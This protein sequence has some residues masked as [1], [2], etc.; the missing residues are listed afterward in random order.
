MLIK[1]TVVLTPAGANKATL[2]FLRDNVQD[3]RNLHEV[4]EQ[5]RGQRRSNAENALAEPDPE[6]TNTV[7]NAY[8]DI[9]WMPTTANGLRKSLLEDVEGQDKKNA[10]GEA[11]NK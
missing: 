7:M 3:K 10:S 6:G 8:E 4:F 2:D 1:P 9:K 5:T 11:M